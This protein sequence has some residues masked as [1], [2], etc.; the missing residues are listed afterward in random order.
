MSKTP[1]I[2]GQRRRDRRYAVHLEVRW[3]L[4]RRRRVLETGTGFTLDLSSGGILLDAG[5][6]LPEGFNLELSVAWP[7][8]QNASPLQ[9]SVSGRI[10][11][12]DGRLAA[13]Q[14]VQHEFRTA[15]I[16]ADRRG[17]PAGMSGTRPV[18]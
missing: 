15:G 5:R 1:E 9:L 4:V 7:V 17:T 2:A 14:I 18:C 11:R 6:R 13:I 8:H 10:V 12:S 3:K 16:D